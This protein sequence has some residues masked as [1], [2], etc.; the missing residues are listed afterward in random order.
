[1]KSGLT[2]FLCFF[3]LE[4][5]S[6]QDLSCITAGAGKNTE[7][8]SVTTSC[9][10]HFGRSLD[11]LASH[12]DD[13]SCTTGNSWIGAEYIFQ[14]IDVVKGNYTFSISGFATDLDL[15]VLSACDESMCLSADGVRKSSGREE[16]VNMDLND[17]QNVYIVIDGKFVNNAAFTFTLTCA[18]DICKDFNS[19]SCGSVAQASNT[20]YDNRATDKVDDHPSCGASSYKQHEVIYQLKT[21]KSPITVDLHPL[22][23]KDI[24][25]FVYDDC[26]SGLSNC[27]A[28]GILSPRDESVFLASGGTDSEI[29]VVVDGKTNPVS[30]PTSGTYKLAITC[31]EPCDQKATKINCNSIT[32]ATTKGKANNAS[33]YSCDGAHNKGH[34][35]GPEA[36]FEF[37][38]DDSYDI[39]IGLEILSNSD[40][41][42]YLL[43]SNCSVTSC[44]ASSKSTHPGAPEKI[45]K[46]LSKGKYIVVVEGFRGHSADFILSLFGCGCRID[47]EIKCNMAINGTL[48]GATNS[49]NAIEGDCFSQEVELK[50]EDRLYYFTAPEAGTY[51]FALSGFTYDMDL[52]LT[53]DC[54]DPQ[55]CITRSAKV[56]TAPETIEV[57]LNKGEQVIAAV[58][59][60]IDYQNSK[61]T[62]EVVCQD[63]GSDEDEEDNEDQEN[64]ENNGENG[65]GEGGNEDEGE[66]EN[67]QAKSDTLFCGQ[68]I[69]G[70][71]IGMPS[72]FGRADHTCFVSYS[73]FA[74]GESIIQFE[75]DSDDDILSLHVFHGESGHENLSL[76]VRD[77]EYKEVVNCKGLNFR[78]DKTIRNGES[79]GEFYTDRDDPLPAGTYYAVLDGYSKRV[80][81]DF[82]LALTCSDLDCTSALGLP[83][84]EALVPEST[85]VATNNE[86]IYSFKDDL[87]VGYTGGENIYSF[88]LDSAQ[89]VEITLYGLFE[90]EGFGSDLDMFLFQH[91]CNGDRKMLAYSRNEG[92][93]DEKIRVLLESGEYQLVVDGWR[94]SRAT[95]SLRVSDCFATYCGKAHGKIAS[96]SMVEPDRMQTEFNVFPNPFGDQI[97]LEINRTA[98][99]PSIVTPSGTYIEIKLYDY[100]GRLLNTRMLPGTG[101]STFEISDLFP[102]GS[103][104]VFMLQLIQSEEKF[105]KNVVKW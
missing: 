34:N 4:S 56:G 105:V 43:K 42:L 45:K 77:E 89:E 100:L 73:D 33:Y 14:V 31:G 57:F 30:F 46:K 22:D 102:Q 38:L 95:Y 85:E 86:S 2:L 83:C 103:K 39:E 80:A 92:I 23:K 40:L 51:V 18:S 87:F 53:K 49:F 29:F 69:N 78:A 50:N 8:I 6:A 27:L 90:I 48:V 59:G 9:G 37:E 82:E 68:S 58:D 10:Q 35:W 21:S 52:F 79:I 99:A 93:M 98:S 61:F 67:D 75:K 5:I 19:I 41:N 20:S 101:H 24:D 81:S 88:C 70:S 63:N 11:G 32:H 94:G 44:L 60:I 17:G 65:N 25:L 7:T 28:T 76:F 74:G 72:D 36:L 66:D 12:N 71:T 97:F 96:K 3:L 13:Y 64:D 62:L 84:G 16:S 91:I 26:V 47:G 15:F 104:G 55:A 1:M 54:A